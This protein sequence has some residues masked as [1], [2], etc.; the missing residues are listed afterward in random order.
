[1]RLGRSLLERQPFASPPASRAAATA[2]AAV[3]SPLSAV[4][5]HDVNALLASL[6]LLL[7]NTLA[8]LTDKYSFLMRKNSVPLL[9]LLSS[10][11]CP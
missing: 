2:A 11:C 1:M 10:M 8:S 7:R 3:F 4:L 6:L 9:Q 5:Y